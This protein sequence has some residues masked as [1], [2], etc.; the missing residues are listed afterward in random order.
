MRLGVNGGQ[1]AE[2]ACF[3]TYYMVA[4]RVHVWGAAEKCMHTEHRHRETKRTHRHTN[5]QIQ[6]DT[7]GYM[8]Y[9]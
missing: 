1:H 8:L 7:H 3:A 6:I 4:H 2:P 5:T 9:I